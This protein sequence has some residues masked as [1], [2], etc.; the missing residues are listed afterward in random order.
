MLQNFLTQPLALIVYDD[1]QKKSYAEISRASGDVELYIGRVT[2]EEILISNELEIV[3]LYCQEVALMPDY[4][5]YMDGYIFF[6]SLDYS[7]SIKDFLEINEKE[8]LTPKNPQNHL[9]TSSQKQKSLPAIETAY[10]KIK[11]YIIG[12]DAAIKQVLMALY[13]NR[14]LSHKNLTRSE[15]VAAK[16]NVLLVGPSGVGKTEIV[17]QLE[18]VVNTPVIEVDIQQYSPTGYVGK[19]VMEILENIYNHSNGNL[20]VAE[21]SV[22]FIDE[23]DKKLFH[24]TEETFPL[25]TITQLLKIIEGG[26][27]CLAN[28]KEIDTKSLTVVCAGAFQSLFTK[29]TNK[30]AIGFENYAQEKEIPL[31]KRLAEYGLP[32][33]FLSRMKRLVQLNMLTKE[34]QKRYLLESKLSILNIKSKLFKE[35]GIE[36]HYHPSKD[37]FVSSLIDDFEQNGMK[38][39]G[40][41]GLNSYVSTVFDEVAWDI[42]NKNQTKSI[43]LST[44]QMKQNRL[45]IQKK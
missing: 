45:S 12:Q 35:Q 26:R 28:G 19:D 25:A 34:D 11:E 10:S 18:N 1:N 31:E 13:N 41:R 29:E 23:I 24:N 30:N 33:E 39:L 2:E 36:V 9:K 40:L 22:L 16:E 14:E 43:E 5:F 6:L 32:E 3:E 8:I 37:S 44:E 42:Y 17:R 21:Q 20:E 38:E 7:E 15:I 4:S 27:Y